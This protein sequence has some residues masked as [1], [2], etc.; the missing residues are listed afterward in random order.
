MVSLYCPK[1]KAV[2]FHMLHS[3]VDNKYP[4]YICSRCGHILTKYLKHRV[5]NNGYT[6]FDW[7]Q[8]RID[9]KLCPVCGKPKSEWGN[10]KRKYC[11]DSCE[12]M[13]IYVC[14][15]WQN[16]D[17]KRHLAIARDGQC[18]RC[19]H[20]EIIENHRSESYYGFM[21]LRYH[22]ISH[23]EI[24]NQRQNCT[25][26][27][28]TLHEF[29]CPRD[30]LY[31]DLEPGW[32]NRQNWPDRHIRHEIICLGCDYC[33]TKCY[34]G[35]WFRYVD[36]SSFIVDHIKPIALGGDEFDINNLQTLC[37]EC[38]KRKTKM[39][40]ARIASQRRVERGRYPDIR[41]DEKQIRFEV[42]ST[43]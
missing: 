24:L 38:N 18:I 42:E 16:W 39:D 40:Q 30:N 2:T 8:E 35:F 3:Y 4:R 29:K 13:F 22:V 41:F 17:H 11:S 33:E 32:E 14:C 10:G 9:K 19:G 12:L 6:V 1:C 27:N 23:I 43:S 36:P 20:R 5:L 15:E 31:E 25:K 7:A 37:P 26:E 34:S 28:T 21:N